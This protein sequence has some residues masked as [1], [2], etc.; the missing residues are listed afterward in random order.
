ME[1]P[2]KHMGDIVMEESPHEISPQYNEVL[3]SPVKSNEDDIRWY[4]SIS[5]TPWCR[6]PCQKHI[7][8]KY[9]IPEIPDDFENKSGTD[10]VLKKTSGSGRVSGTRWAL[11]TPPF[12]IF[13]KFIH[14]WNDRLPRHCLKLLQKYSVYSLSPHHCSEFWICTEWKG[15]L[16]WFGL[17]QG[18]RSLFASKVVFS[19]SHSS[20]NA[21]FWKM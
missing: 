16:C 15:L 2:W 9:P 20:V 13:R 12:G 5:C 7:I 19:P 17:H 8:L 18:Q 11:T 1:N 21:T 14:F 6:F 3:T 10:R 4:W